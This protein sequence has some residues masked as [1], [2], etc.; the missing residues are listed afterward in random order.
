MGH[1][2]GGGLSIYRRRY[3]AGVTRDRVALSIIGGLSLVIVGLVGVLL[4][5]HQPGLAWSADVSALPALNAA[6]NATCAALLVAGWLAIRRRRVAMHR[7]CMLAA[8]VASALFLV[9][10]VVYHAVSGSRPFGGEGWIRARYFP[11]LGSHV[12][13]AAGVLPFVLTTVY[14]ARSGQFAPPAP[15]PR[16]APP[17]GVTR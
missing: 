15:P 8:C 9:S 6:L 14:R 11:I 16:R 10:Y 12:R 5:G 13:L 4:L 7:A 2:D 3:H 1:G 17:G